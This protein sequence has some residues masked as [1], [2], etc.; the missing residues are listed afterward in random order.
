MKKRIIISES[1]KKTILGLYNLLKEDVTDDIKVGDTLLREYQGLDEKFLII[2]NKIGTDVNYTETG[3]FYKTGKKEV[4]EKEHET[5]WFKD[6][7][8]YWEKIDK[9]EYDKIIS[10]FDANQKSKNNGVE[11][12]TTNDET[13]KDSDDI[14]D[15]INTD[16]NWD[17]LKITGVVKGMTIKGEITIPNILVSFDGDDKVSEQD[18]TDKNGKFE[19]NLP[20]VGEYV[21]SAAKGDKDYNLKK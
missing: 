8:K 18:E 9:T 15:E 11:K 10:D 12:Q 16:E 17:T 3:L 6:F 4:N 7:Y 19:V 2:I 21:V 13:K 1:E 20:N 14:E 5:E